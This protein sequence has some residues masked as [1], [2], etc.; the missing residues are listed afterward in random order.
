MC[1]GKSRDPSSFPT[2]G[3]SPQNGSLLGLR[4][5]DPDL[6]QHQGAKPADLPIDQPKKFDL[7]INMKTAK[8]LG[9]TIPPDVLFRATEVI[10]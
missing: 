8:A 1:T 7:I 2:W 10:K 5:N 6:F 4:M 3:P 9:I